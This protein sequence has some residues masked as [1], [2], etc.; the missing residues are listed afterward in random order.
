[1]KIRL[2]IPLEAIQGWATKANRNICRAVLREYGDEIMDVAAQ[3][4]AA[5]IPARRK[6]KASPCISTDHT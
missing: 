5:R 1:M 6:G 4:I 2:D 3:E